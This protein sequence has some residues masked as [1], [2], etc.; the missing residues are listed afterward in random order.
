MLSGSQIKTF[1]GQSRNENHEI[2]RPCVSVAPAH[3]KTTRG[4]E[5]GDTHFQQDSSKVWILARK[6]VR[7]SVV[8]ALPSL[9]KEIAGRAFGADAAKKG[10]QSIRIIGIA[11][12]IIVPRI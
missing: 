6:S 11:F 1:L 10:I 3:L 9:T 5:P 8:P 2:V 4:R 12:D 7:K